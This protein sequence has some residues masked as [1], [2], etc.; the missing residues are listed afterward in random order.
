VNVARTL[1]LVARGTTEFLACVLPES[2]AWRP[3]ECGGCDAD[4]ISVIPFPIIRIG[5]GQRPPTTLSQSATGIQAVRGRNLN[6]DDGT[7]RALLDGLSFRVAR[8]SPTRSPSVAE[9]LRRVGDY[10]DM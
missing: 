7:Q 8:Y 3:E 2:T 10:T 1:A 4:K 5:R 6:S 9:A